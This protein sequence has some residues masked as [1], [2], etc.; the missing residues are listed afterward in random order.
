MTDA[1][2]HDVE[3]DASGLNCPLP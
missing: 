1:V 2:A 3:L